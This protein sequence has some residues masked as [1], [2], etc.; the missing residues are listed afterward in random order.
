M[1][2]ASSASALAGG[3]VDGSRRVETHATDRLMDFSIR[4]S[5]DKERAVGTTRQCPQCRADALILLRRHV[6][7]PRLGAPLVTEYYECDCCDSRYKY[8]PA[9][10]R[11]RPDYQ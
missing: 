9:T 1:V 5:F 7:P 11:W 3:G 4:H 6:S 10:D 2:S 8:S